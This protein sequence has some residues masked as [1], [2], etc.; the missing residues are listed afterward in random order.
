MATP[1]ATGL[2]ALLRQA[3]PDLTPLQTKV[4]LMETA[5]DLGVDKNIQGSGR[6]RA[7]LALAKAKG[8]PVPEPP[9]PPEKQGC[10]PTFLVPLVGR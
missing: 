1:H 10:L 6:A 5:L 7:D 9:P 2:S 8:Q 4:A 3:V